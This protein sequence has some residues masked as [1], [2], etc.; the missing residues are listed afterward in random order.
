MDPGA[1][2]FRFTVLWSTGAARFVGQPSASSSAGGGFVARTS[3]A[4]LACGKGDLGCM[5]GSSW[6]GEIGASYFM[7]IFVSCWIVTAGPPGKAA[8]GPKRG[9][10]H[11]PLCSLLCQHVEVDDKARVVSWCDDRSCRSAS[12]KVFDPSISTS[13]AM[14]HR[15][16]CSEGRISASSIHKSHLFWD[17]LESCANPWQ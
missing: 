3:L 6:T 15:I 7:G 16:R 2:V 4:D 14:D 5:S 1:A 13:S 9:S 17:P 8:S 10:T 11:Q 12:K